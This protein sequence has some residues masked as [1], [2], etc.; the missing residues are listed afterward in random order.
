MS[1]SNVD[2]IY[3]LSPLQQG[4]LLHTVHDGA[5]DMYL[6]QHVYIVEGSLDVDAMV[7]AW[8]KVFESHPALRTSFHWDGNDKPLQVVHRDVTPPA[9]QDDWSAL[10]DDEQQERLDAMMAEDRATGFDV[11]VAPL[12]RLHLIRLGA[13]RHALAWTHHHLLLDGW[14]VPIFMNEVMAHY[15]SLTGGGPLPPPAPPFRD[16]IAW[17]QRQDMDAARTFWKEVMDGVTPAAL[18]GMRPPDPRQGTGGV[19]RHVVSLPPALEEGL[20]DAAS[21]HRVTVNTVLHAAWAVVLGRYSGRSDIV[22]GCV[23]SGRPAELPGVDRM[24]GMFVNTLPVRLSVPRDGD[25]GPWLHE[26]QARYADIRRYEFSPL[27]DI[28]KWAGAPGQQLF[29]SLFV[30]DNHSFGVQAEGSPDRQLTV[31]SQTTYDKVSVPMALIVTPAP[32]SEVQLLLHENRAEPGF[33]DGILD[34][35]FTTLKAIVGADRVEQVVAA[36]GPMLTPSEAPDSPSLVDARSGPVVPPATPEEEAVAAVYRD[37]LELTEVDVTTS[38]FDLGGDSFGAVRAV[39]RIEGASVTL[40]ALNPSVRALAAALSAG[41]LTSEEDELDAEIAELERQLA[42][43][44]DLANELTA[45]YTT[46]EEDEREAAASGH[47]RLEFERTQ[48]ILLRH[49]P[50]APAVIADIG[51]GTG[52]YALWLAEFGYRVVHRDIV[53]LYVEQ[54]RAAIR[55]DTDVET[56][57][58]DARSLDLADESVAAVLLLGP[59]YHLPRLADRVQVLREARRIVAPGGAVFASAISRWAARMDG[60]LRERIYER[61]PEML[62]HIDQV[63]ETGVLPPLARGGYTAYTHRPDELESEFSSAGLDMTDLVSVEGTAFLLTDLTERMDDPRGHEA[64]LASARAHER[65]PELLGIG[66]HLVATGRR[67]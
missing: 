44:D 22:F 4:M 31:R 8:R 60:V 52:R 17:L 11:A 23:S 47:G 30:L 33:A 14:S 34:C 39:G 1:T 24:I 40:L 10:S 28:K 15:Q 48:E 49:L 53:P 27:S 67:P 63:E 37:I 42:E 12:Q 29:D 3:E 20:R 38:F 65:V 46:S 25:L 43:T 16:Y 21:R 66:P 26:L 50:P 55:P 13:D 35:L 54:L 6:G 18:A 59:L 36:A 51:G 9:H 62:A 56:A 45:F 19:D 32:V 57:V 58:G 5:T 64:I 2:D 61:G 7:R 41:G